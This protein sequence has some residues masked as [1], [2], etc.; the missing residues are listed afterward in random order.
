MNVILD[1]TTGRATIV[2]TSADKAKLVEAI[3]AAH[4]SAERA[5]SSSR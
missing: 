2:R 1:F 4:E 3:H 5:T